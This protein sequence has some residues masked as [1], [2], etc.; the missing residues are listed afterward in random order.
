VAAG[1]VSTVLIKRHVVQYN[2]NNKVISTNK[3]HVLFLTVLKFNVL[4]VMFSKQMYV[5]NSI[6][7]DVT[8]C[9]PVEDISE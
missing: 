3:S 2:R 1:K 8:R 4:L 6:F 7:W 9:S 5:K